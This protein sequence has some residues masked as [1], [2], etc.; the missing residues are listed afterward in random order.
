[1]GERGGCEGWWPV[2]IKAPPGANLGAEQEPLIT[3]TNRREER[4]STLNPAWAA[5]ACLLRSGGQG[6]YQAVLYGGIA[7]SGLAKRA[8]SEN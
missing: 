2:Q 1:M 7:V 3:R 5:S 6:C 4:G 8:K